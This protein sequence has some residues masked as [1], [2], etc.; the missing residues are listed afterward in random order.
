MG[1]TTFSGPVV[2]NNGFV[3]SGTNTI[4]I[5]DVSSDADIG[6]DLTIIGTTTLGIYSYTGAPSADVAGTASVIYMSNGA[7][8]SP[9]LVFSDGS[10]WLRCDTL[11]TALPTNT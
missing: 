7:S 1:T 11:G 5:L 3:G 2:S 10:D 4:E 6:G 8:G 9:V